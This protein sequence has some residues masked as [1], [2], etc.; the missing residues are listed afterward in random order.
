MST[1]PV[2][3][4][5]ACG[6]EYDHPVQY[7]SQCGAPNDAAMRKQQIET[8]LHSEEPAPVSGAPFTP[9]PPAAPAV[10][11][12]NRSTA[13]SSEPGSPAVL[14]DLGNAASQ[15]YGTESAPPEAAET[16]AKRKF[17]KKG[18]WIAGGVALLTVIAIVIGVVIGGFH[19]SPKR[20]V[21]EF[22]RLYEKGD[23]EGLY[24]LVDP[25]YLKDNG[26][27][28][29]DLFPSNPIRSYT[30]VNLRYVD[31]VVGI[32]KVYAKCILE[33][34]ISNE[35]EDVQRTSQT[36]LELIN[37]DGTWYFTAESFY[38]IHLTFGLP[39]DSRSS[40]M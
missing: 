27:S 34:M 5:P 16:A 15:P 6:R 2:Y 7:C 14:Q 17:S 37:R 11:T 36:S 26:L 30:H 19:S 28:A 13:S 22:I 29:E 18:W 35:K 4:C 32:D 12:A 24:D 39:N 31:I 8:I 40:E 20:V 21:N 23:K 3:R 25:V 10:F 33:Y 1:M 38:T 9:C